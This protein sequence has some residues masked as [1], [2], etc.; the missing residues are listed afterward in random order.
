MPHLIIFSAKL[1]I[2]RLQRDLTDSTVL[3]NNMGVGFGYSLIAYLSTLKGFSKLNLTNH[4]LEKDLDNLAWEDAT[5]LNSNHCEKA[6]YRKA[7][8]ETQRVNS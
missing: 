2:S 4:I 8:R 6:W 1:P 3:R 7:L 5:N